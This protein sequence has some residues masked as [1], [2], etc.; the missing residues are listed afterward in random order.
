MKE[1]NVILVA[2]FADL[3]SERDYN[4]VIWE[5]TNNTIRAVNFEVGAKRIDSD[6]TRIAMPVKPQKETE[7]IAEA[8]RRKLKLNRVNENVGVHDSRLWQS[9]SIFWDSQEFFA[10]QF[11]DSPRMSDL[12]IVGWIEYVKWILSHN[13]WYGIDSPSK[14]DYG[15]VHTVPY[16]EQ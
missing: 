15:T 5:L 8:I 4:N 2:S 14:V 10:S 1:R 7:E 11:N 9:R 12:I 3:P 16:N 6:S 13:Q